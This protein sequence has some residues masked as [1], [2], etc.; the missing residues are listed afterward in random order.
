MIYV[1]AKE[2]LIYIS[3]FFKCHFDIGVNFYRDFNKG[4][5]NVLLGQTKTHH[6]YKKRNW[7]IGCLLFLLR[8]SQLFYLLSSLLRI[9]TATSKYWSETCVAYLY[10]SLYFS[11]P[12]WFKTFIEH[13]LYMR[14]G[15]WRDTTRCPQISDSLLEDTCTQRSNYKTLW[16]R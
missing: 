7:K 13:L 14:H 5:P 8:V 16:Q 9:W 10:Q 2:W 1:N 3:R 4:M 6:I 15:M 11:T 12:V